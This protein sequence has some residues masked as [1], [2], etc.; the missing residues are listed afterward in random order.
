M[1]VRYYMANI[2]VATHDA[3]VEDRESR[4][5]RIE[6]ITTMTAALILLT[7]LS[8]FLLTTG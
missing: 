4:C 8:F 1:L 3:T 6:A 7:M 2:P 5:R